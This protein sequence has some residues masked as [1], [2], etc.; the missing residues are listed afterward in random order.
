MA[1]DDGMDQPRL[2]QSHEG[3]PEA[4]V[5]AVGQPVEITLRFPGNSAGGII[6][7]SPLDGGHTDLDGPVK[8]SSDGSV[9]FHYQPGALPGLYR[10]AIAG[11]QQYQI[12]F[13]AVDPSRPRVSPPSGQ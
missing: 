6:T 1:I 13:Y 3:I 8:I 7:L 11:A 2:C 9:V 5:L 12:S 4:V 10:L